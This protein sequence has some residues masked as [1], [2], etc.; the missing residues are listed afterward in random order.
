MSAKSKTKT[1]QRV[2]DHRRGYKNTP[3]GWIPNEWNFKALGEG[4]D[5]FS[6]QHVL[7]EDCNNSGIGLPY[8]TGPADFSE[9]T[10]KSSKWTDKPT[11]LCRKGDILIIVKGA[12]SGKIVK[13]DAEYCIS[14]QLM[15]IRASGWNSDFLLQFLR[16]K[17][18]RFENIASGLIPGLSRNDLLLE[19]AP[20]PSVPEQKAIAKILLTS[21]AAISKTEQ[22]IAQKE[23]RKK[24]LMQQLLLG[25]KRLP[26]FQGAWKEMHLRDL[27]TERNELG[28]NNLPLL[29]ITGDRGVI[30]QSDSDKRD[31]SNEDKSKYKRI[32]VGDIGYNTMRMWQGRSA[33]SQIEGIVS[34]AYTVVVPRDCADGLFFAYLFKTPK[35]I[36]DFLRNSQ[37]LVEDTLNCK[38]PNFAVVRVR[39]PEKPEQAAIACLL[40]HC[41]DEITILRKK[42]QALQEQK[43]GLMQKLLTGKIRVKA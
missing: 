17:E 5:L 2:V 18:R 23:Q 11:T 32:A 26:G 30:P 37:G 7:S 24:A 28:R 9:R 27:F 3:L 31:N 43:K 40:R 29:S 1:N 34:P 22:L 13:A 10:I 36:H 39:V 14:R 21:D 19:L 6:G 38:Y 35:V 33:L 20:L 12:G 42:V 25:K 16:S 8:L 15:A 41:D 4:I